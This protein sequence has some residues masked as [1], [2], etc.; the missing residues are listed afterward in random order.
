[1]T[2]EQRLE[3]ALADLLSAMAAAR[4]EGAIEPRR[5]L[6]RKS[7]KEA[8]TRLRQ[9]EKEAANLVHGIPLE[10]ATI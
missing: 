10:G 6:P 9:A 2:R 7:Q 4:Y 3:A 5:T 1:M 8:L